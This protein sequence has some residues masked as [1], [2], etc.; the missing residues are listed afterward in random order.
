VLTFIAGFASIIFIPLTAWLVDAY[1]WREA[2]LW[3]AGVY[4]M[5]TIAPHVLVLRRHPED[6]GLL[7]DGFRSFA[8]DSRSLESRAAATS[9]SVLPQA[10]PRAVIEASSAVRSR[11]FRWL[12][13][14]F[15]M[16]ALT[17]T[18]VLVHL[19]P[20]LLERGHDSSFAGAAMGLLG[21]MALPGRLVFTPLGSRWPRPAVTTAIFALG[22][23]ACMAL[24]ATRHAAGVWVFV[25]LFGAGFGAITPARAALVAEICGHHEHGPDGRRAR[26]R[27]GGRRTP[28]A[29]GPQWAATRR[30]ARLLLRRGDG[31]LIFFAPRLDHVV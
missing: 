13:A 20:L 11:S 19:V 21:L 10:S 25:A 28:D 30:G 3:L 16:S 6:V 14:A 9:P 8:D 12:A 15:A 1:G 26:G 23:V 29:A 7:A 2:L 17:T 5:L 22:A 27:L 18:A 31:A 24:L 4:A